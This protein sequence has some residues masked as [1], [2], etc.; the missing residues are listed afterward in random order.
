MTAGAVAVVVVITLVFFSFTSAVQNGIYT[1]VT[2]AAGHLQVHVAGYRGI[3]D[4]RELLIKEQDLV[5]RLARTL[6][7]PDI[8]TA[9]SV[10]GLLESE[11]RSYGIVLQGLN[12]PE[13]V[14]E[15][16]RTQ[17]LAAGDLPA[18]DDVEHIVLGEK[19]ALNLQVGLGDTVYLYAPGTEGYGASAYTVGGIAVLPA[20]ESAAL[21]SLLAAQELAAPE[22]INRLEIVF[23]NFQ[24]E[25][26]DAALPALKTRVQT[27]LGDVYSVETWAE[28]SSEMAGFVAFFSRI[29][30]VL[31]FIF[32]VLAGLLVANTVYLSVIERVREFGVMHALGIPEHKVVA[33][34]LTESVLLCFTGALIGLVVGSLLV[35][36]TAQGISFPAEVTAFLAEQGLPKVF[37]GGVS[38]QQ[39]V[40]TVLFTF[41]TAA[42]AA[43]VPALNAGRLD[44][45]EAMRFTA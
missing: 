10:P 45:A 30:L 24:R 19:L 42:L 3:R 36:L 32:F 38:R 22:A 17:Y 18:P 28:L 39:V 43:L 9:L 11:G 37:Y 40:L 15:R 31:A 4:R 7:S 35:G 16:F 26:D 23:P 6:D 1:S 29:R 5:P 8:V 34:V 13:A 44:P 33:M 41:L 21:S 25:T 27:E 2:Q 12:Q 14:R 20:S